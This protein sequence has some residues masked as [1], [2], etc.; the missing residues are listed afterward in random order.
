M[1]LHLVY[2]SYGGENLKHRP[3]YY[4]KLLTLT[5]FV[6]AA[7]AVPD[8]DVVFVN[9]GPIPAERQR[10]MADR[11]RIVSMGDSAQGLRA[12]YR[13][14]L[15]LP[16]GEQWPDDDVV[17][18]VEDDYLFTEVAMVALAEAAEQL[19]DASYFALYGERP[20]YADPVARTYFGVPD[21]W[22]PQPQ[23]RI[24][25]RVWF[26]LS[27]TTSTFAARVGALRADTDIFLQCMK[28][29]R[30]RFLDHETCIIYQ[31][32][33][34]YRGWDLV[35]GIAGD[36]E[37]SARG[38]VRAAVLVPYRFILNRRAAQQTTPH[39]LYA[40][41]PNAA[42]HLEHPVISPDRDWEA[43]ADEVARWAA[44]QDGMLFV[45]DAIRGQLERAV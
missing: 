2:R 5:S 40:L 11:G 24:G 37:P 8:A 28:P 42:T 7:A 13:F 4:S 9:D 36:F 32:G 35:R 44:Q 22:H 19:E 1:R 14:A 45:A 41:T 12:S 26:N 6:R 31:G 17:F 3:A 23:R 43:V 30:K 27:S 39:Y 16:D 34:P 25:D 33:I 20:D 38:V 21:G 15:D 10:V 29:F 18:Y